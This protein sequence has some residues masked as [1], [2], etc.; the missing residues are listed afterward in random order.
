MSGALDLGG[1]VKPFFGFPYVGGDGGHMTLDCFCK[2]FLCDNTLLQLRMQTEKNLIPT[3][4]K[5]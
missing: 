4:K 5:Q 3:Q 1:G 2:T